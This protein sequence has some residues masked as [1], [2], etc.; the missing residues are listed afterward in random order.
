MCYVSLE[1]I[2]ELLVYNGNVIKSGILNPN[3]KNFR[4]VAESTL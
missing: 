3:T 2:D 4:D 1:F